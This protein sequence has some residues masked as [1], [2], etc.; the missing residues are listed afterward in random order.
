MSD[1]QVTK[2][3]NQTKLSGRAILQDILSS[4]ILRIV[5]AILLAF[6]VGLLLVIFTNERVLNS[7]PNLFAN[8][9]EFFTASAHSIG[10]FFEAFFKGAIFNGN[11]KT[12]EVQIRPLTESLR[13]AGPLIAAG[14]GVA[15]TFRAG[16]FNIGAQGQI[17]M[18]SAFAAFAAFQFHLP[19]GVHLVVAVIFGFAGAAIWAAIAGWLKA[20]TGAHEVIVTIMMNYIGLNLVT[21][22]MRTDILNPGATTSTPQAVAPEP[23]AILP[24]LLGPSFKLHWGFVLVLLSVLAYWWLVEKSSIGFKMRAIGI[25]PEAAKTAG[26]NV[27]RLYVMAMAFSGL[28]VGIAAVNQS[29]GDGLRIT[30]RIDEGIGFEAITVAL[31][32]GSRAFG[33]LAAG[34]LFGAMKATGPAMQAAGVSPDILSVVQGLIILFVAAPPLI[35]AMF[36]LPAPRLAVDVAATTT[37]TSYKKPKKAVAAKDDAKTK[38]LTNGEGS[39]K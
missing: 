17:L 25:N 2:Q 23:N 20:Q 34:L 21:F 29:L 13:F 18:G 31:L 11:G 26:M 5:I 3:N 39:D 27:K 8:P 30:P 14:L 37:N 36:R 19:I 4:S 32:G 16:M 24:L 38:E 15:L 22:A 6:V 1:S 10:A 9:G 12:F 28:F 35:R 7:L 33:V